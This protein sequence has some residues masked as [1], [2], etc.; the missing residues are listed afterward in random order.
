MVLCVLNVGVV[1]AVTDSKE[2]WCKDGSYSVCSFYEYIAL[3]VC[4]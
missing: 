4:T 2:S 1:G 3:L